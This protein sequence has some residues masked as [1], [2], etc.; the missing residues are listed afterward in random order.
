M[1]KL[2]AAVFAALV[3]PEARRYEYALALVV[4]EAVRAAFGH[5]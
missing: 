4:Y 5:P 3:S 2:L 1:K